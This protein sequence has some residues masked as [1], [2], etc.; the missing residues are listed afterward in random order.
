[1][2]KVKSGYYQ[3]LSTFPN[4]QLNLK[5]TNK[6]SGTGRSKGQGRGEAGFRRALNNV[7]KGYFF[8]H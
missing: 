7:L 2:Q 6:H 5:L 1:M 3:S 4:R 8:G